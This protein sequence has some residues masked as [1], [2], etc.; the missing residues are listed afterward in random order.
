MHIT[1][2]ERMATETAQQREA[3]LQ[4]LCANQSER[5]A[6]ET[7]EQREARLQRVC[8]TLKNVDRWTFCFRFATFPDH[9][10]QS[11]DSSHIYALHVTSNIYCVLPVI[12]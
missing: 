7:E 12:Y 3:R 10:V 5:L 2:S 1:H 6:A 8:I 9:T 4:M 11:S